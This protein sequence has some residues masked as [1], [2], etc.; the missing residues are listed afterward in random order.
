MNIYV[1]YQSDTERGEDT[2][3]V[4]AYKTYEQAFIELKSD[5]ID[6]I[7]GCIEFDHPNL[8]ETDLKN[9]IDD[10]FSQSLKTSNE[11]FES[12][13]VY[14]LSVYGIQCINLSN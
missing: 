12:I 10:E 14:G 8:S 9:L 3:I 5:M 2:T 1:Y 7:K 13:Y 11:K 6:F 4:S